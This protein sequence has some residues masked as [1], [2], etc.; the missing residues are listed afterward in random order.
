MGAGTIAKSKTVNGAQWY[1]KVSTAF[2]Y[3]AMVVLLLFPGIPETAANLLIL[4]CGGLMMLSFVMYAR[5]YRVKQRK[6]EPEI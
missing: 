1:G 6:A 5:Y 2:F 4:C 3:A